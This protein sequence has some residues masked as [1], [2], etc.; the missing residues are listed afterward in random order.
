MKVDVIVIGSG[1][2]GLAIA[3]ALGRQKLKAL[4]IG[5]DIAA[6]NFDFEY[7][8]ENSTITNLP[9]MFAAESIAF[10]SSKKSV[11]ISKNLLCVDSKSLYQRFLMSCADNGVGMMHGRAV[12]VVSYRK[13]HRVDWIPNQVADVQLP[14]E[15]LFAPLV[16]DASGGSSLFSPKPAGF[17]TVFRKVLRGSGSYFEKQFS[18]FENETTAQDSVGIQSF[19]RGFQHEDGRYFLEEI[20]LSSETPIAE[21]V[22]KDRLLARLDVSKFTIEEE[23]GESYSFTP[24]FCEDRSSKLLA[25]GDAAA[26]ANPMTGEATSRV[27][28]RAPKLAK[29]ISESMD[30]SPQEIADLGRESL[31]NDNER[32]LE[33]ALWFVCNEMSSSLNGQEELFETL[34]NSGSFFDAV[35]FGTSLDAETFSGLAE[36]MKSTGSSKAFDEFSQFDPI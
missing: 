1:I 11:E 30:K 15:E 13:L 6:S 3:A 35:M 32:Q 22:L 16:I 31:F 19:C 36:L 27:I 4:V 26:M 25:F 24:V 2:A 14:K 9:D 28:N 23:N 20:C 10:R 33:K 7:V 8:F 21:E 29:V 17:S 18:Y 12:K 34:F 5:P